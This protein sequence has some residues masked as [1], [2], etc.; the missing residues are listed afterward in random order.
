MMETAKVDIRK[1]QLL[2]DRIN[3]CLDALNQVRYSV[4]G[5]SHSAQPPATFNPGAWGGQTG[6][7]GFQDPRFAQDP[8]LAQDPRFAAATPSLGLSHTAHT[9][10][11]YPQLGPQIPGYGQGPFGMPAA[12]NPVGGLSHSGPEVE[13]GRPLAAD[14]F[15]VGRIVQTFPYAQLAI[16]PVMAIP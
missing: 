15:L 11:P 12:W 6:P 16:P 3:Q 1:L 4:Y 7:F 10:N 2:N 8:R 9:P 13:I 5:L 14:P